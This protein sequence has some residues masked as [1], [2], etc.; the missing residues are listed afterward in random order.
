MQAIEEKIKD[1]GQWIDDPTPAQV[2]SMVETS[3]PVLGIDEK[4]HKGRKRR[5]SQLAW[6]AVIKELRISKTKKLELLQTLIDD[7]SSL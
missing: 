5:F 4:T 6:L 2:I 7:A 1:L 3:I